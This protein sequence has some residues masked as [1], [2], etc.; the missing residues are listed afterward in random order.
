MHHE[1]HEPQRLSQPDQRRQPS[2][3]RDQ[4]PKELTENI[5]VEP[6]GLGWETHAAFLRYRTNRCNPGQVFL[7]HR[8]PCAGNTSWRGS[9]GT[10]W[11]VTEERRNV[12]VGRYGEWSR[13]RA[14]Y[15]SVADVNCD[16]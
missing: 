15:C 14:E 12:R 6:R 3:D 4:R 16:V 1:L 8:W 7:R 10:P 9:I 2:G 11:G 13:R 5:P